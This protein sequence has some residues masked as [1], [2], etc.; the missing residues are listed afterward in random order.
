M[1]GLPGSIPAATEYKSRWHQLCLPLRGTARGVRGA[2]CGSD[3]V[4]MGRRP[5][6]WRSQAHPLGAL[7]RCGH[8][9]LL[10]VGLPAADRTGI[11]V[12]LLLALVIVQNGLMALPA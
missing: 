12:P 10:P 8:D 6:G 5:G 2:A 4:R 11:A 3:Q 9:P 1:P 7:G